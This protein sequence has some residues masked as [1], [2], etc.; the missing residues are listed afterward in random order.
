MDLEAIPAIDHHAHN[1]L[2][3]AA[4]ARRTFA[5]SFTESDDPEVVQRFA[6]QT[7]FWRRSLRDLAALLD[8]APEEEALLR[9]REEL[10]LEKLTAG[11]LGAA[12]LE[13]VLLD[14]GFLSGEI[15]PLV[16]HEQFV[17]TRRVLRLEKLAEDLIPTARDF[18]DFLERFRG[19]LEQPP[20]DVVSFKSI[21]AY[22]SGLEVRDVHRQEAAWRFRQLPPGP[23]RLTDK[24]L[25]DFLF[26]Q[27]LEV[28]ARH[29]MP[30]QLHTG[31][32]DPDL[33][34]RMANPLHL[35]AV[36]EDRRFRGVPLVL[37]HASY[38]Y[39]R[40]AGYLASAYANVYVDFGLAVPFL[41]VAGMR[42]ALAQL[43]EL[44]PTNKVLY[45][46]DAHC[47]PELF[48]L[49]AKW[50]R[51]VLGDV[52]ESTVRDGDLTAQ[53]ADEV[54]AAVL[55]ANARTLYRLSHC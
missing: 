21:A 11:C 53:Q 35:R 28:A 12:R 40:E 10:G 54:A 50:G 22:R 7:L 55:H 20:A 37:L 49:G 39:A 41:S 47:V 23:L 26:F 8:C 4:A 30:V 14:D 6:R 25:I 24:P 15:L 29:A 51:R 5:A 1:V 17:P 27:A 33:D 19:V 32:G 38:P 34:L 42:A 44:A 13:M 3:L 52:L 45:A 9:R 48:F 2:T 36:L 31:F 18:D 43:L 16:W 46:S